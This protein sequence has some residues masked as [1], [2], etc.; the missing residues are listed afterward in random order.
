MATRTPGNNAPTSPEFSRSPGA[1]DLYIAQ[2]QIKSKLSSSIA[3]E[4]GIS[5]PSS[6]FSQELQTPS[7]LP[8]PRPRKPKT[9]SSESSSNMQADTAVAYP[10]G[11]RLSVGSLRYESDSSQQSYRRPSAP[12]AYF[13]GTQGTLYAKNMNGSLSSLS[14]FSNLFYQPSPAPHR[15]SLIATPVTPAKIN[16]DVTSALEQ[17]ALVDDY[18]E[19]LY[20]DLSTPSSAHSSRSNL[21]NNVRPVSLTIPSAVVKRKPIPAFEEAPGN[22]PESPVEFSNIIANP[23]NNASSTTVALPPR[24]SAKAERIL[25]M[26]SASPSR[27]SSRRSSGSSQQ[28]ARISRDPERGPHDNNAVR[29][30]FIDLSNSEAETPATPASN[31][32]GGSPFSFT[33]ELP[34]FTKRRAESINGS[35]NNTTLGD[36]KALL[37]VVEAKRGSATSTDVDDHHSDSEDSLQEKRK[38]LVDG[39]DIKKKKTIPGM[40]V[41]PST[42]NVLDHRERSDLIRQNRKI[43]QMLGPG[44]FVKS[45]VIGRIR[46]NSDSILKKK[47][48]GG[49]RSVQSAGPIPVTEID[50][51]P[52]SSWEVLNRETI[53][54]NAT[55]RRHSSPLSS[56]IYEYKDDEDG[57][58]DLKS[59]AD[60]L[61][62]D[63]GSGDQKHETRSASPTSFMELSDEEGMRT[64][65]RSRSADILNE[66]QERDPPNSSKFYELD[67]PSPNAMNG[68]YSSF[69][70]SMN[71]KLSEEEDEWKAERRQKRAKLAKI[72]RYLGS[73]VPAE[74]VLGYSSS[75]IPPAAPQRESPDHGKARKSRARS[76]STNDQYG[77]ESS[78]MSSESRNLDTMKEKE[79]ML[80]IRRTAKIEQ[81]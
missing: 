6:S 49:H 41:K 53:Y 27:Q 78:H 55:G 20:P 61:M 47:H 43:A 68:S 35:H 59:L 12:A 56:S 34:T 67:T 19:L 79:R 4:L 77:S 14:S 69:Q 30:S 33:S 64:P 10:L 5:S 62:S 25:G 16:T 13:Q 75:T 46:G 36:Y 21:I 8:P 81:V 54:M 57:D 45:K 26:S 51:I 48:D 18:S 42:S 22:A 44:A 2:Q 39:S 72:H 71:S 17:E 29:E 3:L 9:T 50:G 37:G 32:P 60:S 52:R 38:V 7:L 80:Q 74:L 73:K 15:N 28:F 24:P 11:G 40:P 23:S 65:R 70:D 76:A 31:K 66:E 63:S 1:F 58:A